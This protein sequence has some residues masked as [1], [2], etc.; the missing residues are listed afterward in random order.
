MTPGSK[1]KLPRLSTAWQLV[2]L[3]GREREERCHFS[4]VCTQDF[5]KNKELR[6]PFA[7]PL[8]IYTCLFPL[9]SLLSF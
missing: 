7:S 8:P 9:M 3:W 4:S 2:D 6:F 1:A 5:R